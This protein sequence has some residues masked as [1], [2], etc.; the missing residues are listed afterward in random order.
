[1]IPLWV[2]AHPRLPSYVYAHTHSGMAQAQNIK[3]YATY[4]EERVAAYRELKT[5][6]V[7]AADDAT[8]ANRLASMKW[9]EGL[10]REL[11]V[12]LRQSKCL[13]TNRFYLDSVDNDITTEALRL[14]VQD[15]MRLAQII[16]SAVINVLRRSRGG[17]TYEVGG[18]HT[19]TYCG[20]ST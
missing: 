18:T 12:L 17:S 14:L 5:D 1:M 19:F 3:A 11:E 20:R 15:L 2:N 6:Y 10:Q 8:T 9:K 7:I 13:L 4:L 16:T